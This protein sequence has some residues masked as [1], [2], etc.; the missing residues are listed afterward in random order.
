MPNGIIV[1][2]REGCIQQ[3]NPAGEKILNMTQDT[4]KGCLAA[5]VFSSLD[6][7]NVL[8]KAHHLVGVQ[9][10]MNDVMVLCNISP[11][12][13]MEGAVIVFQALTDFDRVALELEATKRLYETLLT[14]TNN[15]YEAKMK[16]RLSKVVPTLFPVCLLCAKGELLEQWA[17]LFFRN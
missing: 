8:Q 4:I 12:G 13:E 15:A 7:S 1:V 17:K 14:V 10:Q 6:L 16:F 11:M 5:R 2:D 9:A 3:I